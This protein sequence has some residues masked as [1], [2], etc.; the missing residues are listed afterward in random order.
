MCHHIDIPGP[1]S[2]G[3]P[4]LIPCASGPQSGPPCSEPWEVSL[5]L[6]QTLDFLISPV[7]VKTPA[8]EIPARIVDL[9]SVLLAAPV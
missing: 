7:V 4:G 6:F 3:T 2:S 8:S 5:D 1:Q 9:S